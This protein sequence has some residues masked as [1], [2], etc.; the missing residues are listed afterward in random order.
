MRNNEDLFDFYSMEVCCVFSLE[1]PPM[2]DSNE[3]TQYTIVSIK[4]EKIPLIV[5]SLPLWGFFK[6]L[7]NEFETAMVNELSVFE[8]LKSYCMYITIAVSLKLQAPCAG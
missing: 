1:S 2:G 6:G 3:Y 4:K 7:K 8:P 5:L